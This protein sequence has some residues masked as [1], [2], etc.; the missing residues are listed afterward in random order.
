MYQHGKK[1]HRPRN[2]KVYLYT[3]ITFGVAL[4]VAAFILQNDLASKTQEKTTV[5]IVT[6]VGNE[7]QDMMLINEPLFTMELPSDWEQT[8][9]VQESYAN[10]YEWHSTV[11]GGDD[12]RL[13]LHIDIMPQER[14]YVRL[15]PLTIN[16]NKFNLGNLSGDCAD[17][18]TNVAAAQSSAPAEAKWEGSTFLCDPISANQTIGT[19]TVQTGIGAKIGQHRYFFY[20]EDH[21]IRPDDKI[22]QDALRS[23]VAR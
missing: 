7:K 6:E 17:F 11:R 22:L 8:N 23:F 13:E 1:S 2:P 21:N 20:Y 4:I 5:P 9:R 3:A 12:R 19:G 10:F 14:K 16:G 15:Q 18:A